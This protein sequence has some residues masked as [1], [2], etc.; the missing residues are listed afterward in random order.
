MTNTL[1]ARRYADALFA[2]GRKQGKASLSGYGSSLDELARLCQEEP[3]FGHLLKSPVIS[4]EEKKAVLTAVLDRLEADRI[5]RNFCS[6]LADKDRLGEIPGI[7]DWYNML[8]DNENGVLRGRVITAIAL[9][10]ER[11]ESLKKSL[12]EKAGQQMELQFEIDPEILG[13]LVLA[14]GDRVLDTSLRAQ[15]GALGDIMK[16]GI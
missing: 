11:R 9:S 15:L 5:L 2:L 8:L 16:R 6:L 14:I 3:R 13:G 4:V 1:V 7:A 10:P 12:E